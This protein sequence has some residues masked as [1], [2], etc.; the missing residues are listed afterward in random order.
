MEI[1]F[2]GTSSGVPS[3]TRNTSATAVTFDRTKSWCLVDCGE[4]T[5]HQL[6]KSELSIFHLDLICISHVHGDHCYGLPGLL[7]SMSMN[8]KRSAVHIIAPNSV[9]QWLHCTFSMSKT[10]LSFDLFAHSID[11]ITRPLSLAFCSVDIVNLK[12]RVPSYGFKL[13]EVLIPKKLK[14]AK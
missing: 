11:D 7:S 3:K 1:H 2:L 9:I 5:Q 14:L 12:H 13:S 6:Q 10:S 4:A 8:N